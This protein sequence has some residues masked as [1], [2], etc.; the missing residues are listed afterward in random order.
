MHGAVAIYADDGGSSVTIPI[1]PMM[2]PNARW[3][4]VLVYTEPNDAKGAAI[5]DINAAV[6]D[7]AVKIGAEAG[8]PVHLFSLA[9]AAK[10]HEAV[11]NGVTGRSLITVADL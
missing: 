10:A 8:L 9:D 6:S 11:E 1:R 7:G 2:G 4:F 3:Q 5:E